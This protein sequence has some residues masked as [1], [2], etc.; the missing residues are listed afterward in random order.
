MMK[1]RLFLY[2]FVGLLVFVGCSDD[3]FEDQPARPHEF[4]LERNSVTAEYTEGFANINMVAD[5]AITWTATCSADWLSVSP[6]SGTGGTNIC[7]TW[8]ENTAAADREATITFSEGQKEI[9]LTVTQGQKPAELVSARAIVGNLVKYEQDSVEF[10][11]DRPVG[12]VFVASNSEFYAIDTQ[13]E[14]VDDDGYCWRVPLKIASLGSDIQLAVS[15]KSVSDW[16]EHKKGVSV[17]FYEKKYLLSEETGWIKYSTLSLDK[18]SIWIAVENWDADKNKVVQV[19]LDD[20]TVMQSVKMPF[21]PTH[22]CMNPYNGRLYVMGNQ[23]YFCVVDPVNGEIVK[24]VQIETSPY[25]HPQYP[26]NC[27]TEVAFTKDGFGVLRLMSPSTTGHEWRYI[28]SADD[29]KIT[30][31]GENNEYEFERLYVNYDQ[32]RIY[33]NMYPSLYCPMAWVNRQH[34]KPVEVNISASFQSDKYYAGGNLVDLQMSPFANKA[35]I[36]T[37]P[38]SECVVGLDPLSYSEVIIMEARDSKCAWDE[39]MKERDYVYQVCGYDGFF[40]LFDMTA[41]NTIFGANHRFIGGNE[42]KNCHFLPATDQL[43]VSA[44][45]GVWVFDAA[46]IKAKR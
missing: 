38:G 6:T 2:V 40:E 43:V 27:A 19:S 36:C 25:A 18:K 3:H 39:A 24:R 21:A 5:L 11:F 8:Q 20:M 31:S 45:D 10:V 35:Y 26:E 16:V 1:V 30:L 12:W 34:Q 4:K 13:A 7:V 15:Y 28:D 22:L 23:E 42:A 17:P 33:A 29:D 37:S 46:A 41:G 9:E 44:L 14:K 32:S